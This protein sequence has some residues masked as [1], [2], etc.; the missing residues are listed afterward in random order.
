MGVAVVID[1]KSCEI[2][3]LKVLASNLYEKCTCNFADTPQYHRYF[4]SPLCVVC[5]IRSE[6]A[7]HYA[8]YE[9]RNDDTITV[10]LTT[11]IC[12]KKIIPKS[13]AQSVQLI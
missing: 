4:E 8:Y 1:V 12:V 11:M 3:R 7:H 6:K 10:T 13:K 2:E 9:E 5:W